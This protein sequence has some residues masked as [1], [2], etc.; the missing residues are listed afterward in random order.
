MLFLIAILI[1]LKPLLFQNSEQT[2]G[3]PTPKGIALLSVS[4][5]IGRVSNV[6]RQ[7]FMKGSLTQVDPFVLW[8]SLIHS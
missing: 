8:L 3:S 1:Q 7:G 2:T 5:T 6:G 4:Q